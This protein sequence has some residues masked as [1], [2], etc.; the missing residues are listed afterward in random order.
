[1][2]RRFFNLRWTHLNRIQVK[3]CI[4]L[5]M[6]CTVFKM[7]PGGGA[8]KPP[9]NFFGGHCGAF[10][11]RFLVVWRRLQKNMGLENIIFLCNPHFGRCAHCW[12][13][14]N[15]RSFG[16]LKVHEHNTM[17]PRKYA[18]LHREGRQIDTDGT[19]GGGRVVAARHNRLEDARDA[20]TAAPTV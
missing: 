16:L 10:F 12:T 15:R 11:T 14:A 8:A 20:R 1:M 6:G 17:N 13:A 9:R 4:L 5:K 19:P 2:Y 3:A 7:S 18:V